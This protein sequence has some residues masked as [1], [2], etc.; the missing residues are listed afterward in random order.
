MSDVIKEFLVGIGYKIDE[1]GQRRFVDGVNNATDTVH[2][3]ST[4]LKALA[5]GAAIYGVVHWFDKV[6][7]SMEGMYY[8]AQRAGSSVKEL[9]SFT[10]AASQMGS[11]A[12]QALSNAQ[13]I[14]QFFRNQPNAPNWLQSHLGVNA[15]DAKGKLKS[16]V[17]LA[18]EIGAALNKQPL[19]LQAQYAEQTQMPLELRMALRRAA[20]FKQFQ[21]QYEA[22]LR[23]AGLNPDQAA[24][25][26]R[27]FQRG[28][29]SI[30]AA[31]DI[32][33][34]AVMGALTGHNGATGALGRF[35]DMILSHIPQI[36]RILS[37]LADAGVTA[38]G[39]FLDW[40]DT[41]DWNKVFSK[42]EAFF[43]WLLSLDPQQMVKYL[44]EIA[45]VLGVIFGL[46]MIAGVASFA[47]GLARLVPLF[48]G[49]ASGLSGIATA[50]GATGTALAAVVGVL[51]A[52]AAG[53][54]VGHEIH[55]HLIAGTKADDIIGNVV[56]SFLAAFGN[57]EAQQ[58]IRDADHVGPE[59]HSGDYHPDRVKVSKKTTRGIRNNN[60]GNLIYND[61]TR[62]LGATGADANGFAIFPT[63]QA[64]LN[65]I[66]ANLAS[67]ARKGVNTP[68]EIAHRWSQTDQAAY[69]AA[70]AKALGVNPN[71]PLNLSDPKVINALRNGIIMQENGRNPYASEMPRSAP[72]AS[73]GAPPNTSLTATTTIQV[74]GSSNPLATA[75]AV[76]NKQADVNQRLVRNFRQVF[77]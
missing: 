19:Y 22:M 27:N 61:F 72:V 6:T 4:A 51:A 62:G 66:A 26:A 75:Q 58:A 70:L 34:N 54:F 64:G 76:A 60:P 57:E 59:N 36:T 40:L 1:A 32:V 14:Y 50:A 7:G 73:A 23:R 13:A 42:I 67:Y 33:K 20:Q 39:K 29:R 53:G 68:F 47:G 55:K 18:E 15:L 35:R 30:G 43:D 17:Q 63:P 5:T 25:Q 44:K 71:Q 28:A 8:A 45:V 41:V 69:T 11:S 16:G 9:Q 77:A 21:N 48:G 37:R 24:E 52:A 2:K 10:Y 38:F 12:S 74:Q 46:K 3:L 65:A 56:T 31:F 49:L